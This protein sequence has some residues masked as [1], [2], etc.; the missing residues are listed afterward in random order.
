MKRQTPLA[1]GVRK[2]PYQ[3]Y[4]GLH[5][6]ALDLADIVAWRAFSLKRL[7]P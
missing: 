5:S 2:G 3:T 1:G 7:E 4:D 6:T